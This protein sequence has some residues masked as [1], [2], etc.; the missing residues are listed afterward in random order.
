MTIDK[1]RMTIDKLRMTIDKLRMTI[2]SRL[3]NRYAA[4]F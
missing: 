1:L 2:L 3:R 4:G